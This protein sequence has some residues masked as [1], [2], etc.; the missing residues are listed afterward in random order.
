M[1]SIPDYYAILQVPVTSTHDEIREAYKRQ[2]L[3]NHP[4]RL[5]TTASQQDRE[6]ATRKFQLVA[7][8]YYILGD[9]SRREAYDKSRSKQEGFAPFNA[10]RPKASTSQ[11]NH[12]FG[13]IF[14]ELLKPDVEHP[15]HIW[16]IIG[17]GAGAVLGFIIGNVPGAAIGALAGKTLGQVRDHKGVSVYTAFQK[18]DGDQRR[19]ILTSLLARFVTAG[20]SGMMK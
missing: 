4:D 15:T 20:A 9:R 1:A 14:E 2:A 18:L 12:L 3:V 7:D 8:A 13:D 6:E 11:A 5:P 19:N 16:R 17:A 10:A